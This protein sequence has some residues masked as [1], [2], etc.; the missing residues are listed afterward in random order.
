MATI[1]DS[2]LVT[3]GLESSG[4]EKGRAKVDD[5]LKKTK[6]S[7]DD[8][9]KS[10]GEVAK[11]FAKFLAVVGGTVAIKRFA[12][13]LIE[14]SAA[15]DRLS[16]NIGV[17]ADT[18]SAWSNAAELAGGSASGLQGTMDM[19]SKSQT[20][21]MLTGESGLIPYFSALGMSLADAQG[22]A[23]PV[24]DI[25]LELA[26]RF[27]KMDRT[28]ANNMGRMM[29]IDQGTMQLLLKGRAEVE[30]TIKRQ[31]EY[32][33]VTKQQ[34][35]ESSRLQ[36][37]MIA[38]RQSFEAFGREL[39]SQATPALEKLFSIFSGFGD[40]IRN[41]QE[42]VS[43]F[44]KVLGIGLGVFI[45]ATAPINL[46]VAAVIA[47]AAA[48][49]GLWQDYQTWARGGQSLFDWTNFVSGI[50]IAKETV[51]GLTDTI[52]DLLYVALA[53]GDALIK[54]ATG[55]WS[56][57]KIAAKAFWQGRESDYNTGAATEG[58][59]MPSREYSDKKLRE[60]EGKYGLPS[61]LLDSVY[62]AESGR[63]KN[64]KSS[65]GAEGPFQFMP[66]T[67]KQYGLSNPY[68]FN[69][70]ADAAA[71]YYRDLLQH[72]GGDVNKAIAAYNWGPGNVDQKGM[73]NLPG[74]T[75]G[76][77]AKVLGGIPGASQAAIGS[78]AGGGM[79]M[80]GG[81]RSS[82]VNIGAITV[83]TAATDAPGIAK[84]MGKSMEYLF[85]SQVNGGL[86]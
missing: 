4:F 38:S 34:A 9:N 42:F 11:T 27:S 86:F 15:L 53:G 77:M 64:L 66:G 47:L 41:N 52:A 68:D 56:G 30:L 43:D 71:R 3:L 79:S 55:D 32:G 20:D 76:Y 23:R 29:G 57:A 75:R 12:E 45:A 54:L 16:K 49:A 40:W 24:T 36:R 69:A 25:L 21:L 39:L 61:G 6:K 50:K 63:G 83:N 78:G 67:A 31:K 18:I 60:L 7:A 70:S 1:I 58:S 26:D 22:K 81:N 62:A 80:M 10:V 51:Q 46:T 37:A 33:A 84:D 2:L 74:E 14:S 28:T 44:L 19:L 5:G 73:G 59:A 72:Y 17:S 65:A 13:H 85:T 82:E 48:F 35:E 8:A